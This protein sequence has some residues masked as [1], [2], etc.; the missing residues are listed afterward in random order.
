MALVPKI[1]APPH[2]VKRAARIPVALGLGLAAI[3]AGS[4]SAADVASNVD[5]LYC[6]LPEYGDVLVGSTEA[7]EKLQWVDEAE[8]NLPDKADLPDIETS[9]WLPTPK[10]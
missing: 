7:G 6:D 1:T 2:T 4:S 8:A 9:T 10:T 5:S 3:V